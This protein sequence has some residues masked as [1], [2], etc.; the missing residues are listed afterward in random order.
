MSFAL[1]IS[2]GADH[3][4]LY[5]LLISSEGAVRSHSLFWSCNKHSFWTNAAS[6]DLEKED[7]SVIS[8]YHDDLQFLDNDV[9]Q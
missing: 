5:H 9:C 7:D 1:K 4:H 6:Y 3:L 8:F 2:A